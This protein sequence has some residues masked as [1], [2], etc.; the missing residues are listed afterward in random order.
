MSTYT[1]SLPSTLPIS[2]SE[3]SIHLRLDEIADEETSLL[4]QMIYTATQEAE[5][6]MQREIIKRGDAL[7]VCESADTVPFCIKQY[8]LAEAGFLYKHRE[9]QGTDNLHRYH[10]HLLD[11]YILYNRVDGDDVEEDDD[12]EDGE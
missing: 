9:I 2:V 5:H 10:I 12:E 1:D 3:L 8:L 4:Q 11:P 6:Y 7:A